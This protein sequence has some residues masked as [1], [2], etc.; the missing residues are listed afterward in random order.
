MLFFWQLGNSATLLLFS[1]GVPRLPHLT[2]LHILYVQGHKLWSTDDIFI[3]AVTALI[4]SMPISSI[5]FRIYSPGQ[6]IF[7]V[8]VVFVF[9]FEY[10]LSKICRGPKKLHF[11]QYCDKQF[12]LNWLVIRHEKGCRDR[13]G[14]IN[15]NVWIDSFFELHC[16]GLANNYSRHLWFI[17]WSWSFVCIADQDENW[18]GI[19]S[20]KVE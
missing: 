20:F 12:K 5:L 19:N 8:F 11:C 6:L 13:P 10:I 16:F 7:I 3:L 2:I 1:N 17:H 4:R 14:W 9:N 18:E 15:I